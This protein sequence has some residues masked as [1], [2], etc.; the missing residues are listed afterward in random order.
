MKLA[1][2]PSMLRLR[3][4]GMGGDL[5]SMGCPLTSIRMLLA[6]IVNRE[7]IASNCGLLSQ[8][9][10]FLSPQLRFLSPNILA[11]F[12]TSTLSAQISMAR[13]K[14]A[15]F[16]RASPNVVSFYLAKENLKL[17]LLKPFKKEVYATPSSRSRI[18]TAS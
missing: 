5:R 8:G 13:M 18:S 2:F 16:L 17:P 4:C 3:G 7:S 15:A 1:V 10:G 11:I 9:P 14:S 6:S 12:G